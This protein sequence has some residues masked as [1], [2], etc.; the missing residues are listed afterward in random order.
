MP[1]Q[2]ICRN[3]RV[4]PQ[5]ALQAVQALLLR[6]HGRAQPDPVAGIVLVGLEH[7]R[8]QVAGTDPVAQAQRLDGFAQ[9]GILAAF[10]GI[11]IDVIGHDVSLAQAPTWGK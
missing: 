2:S 6:I 5:G 8:Q 10:E 3:V 11:K 1:W 4:D 7:A 9:D